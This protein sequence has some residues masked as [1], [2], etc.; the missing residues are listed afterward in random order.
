MA[1]SVA[2][3]AD[4]ESYRK[5]R[6]AMIQRGEDPGITNSALSHSSP[7]PNAMGSIPDAAAK[8]M[9][10]K[11]QARKDAVKKLF[12]MKTESLKGGE[13]QSAGAGTKVYDG[14]GKEGGEPIPGHTDPVSR[15]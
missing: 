8:S 11:H 5:R 2:S 14:T 12:G 9:N 4:L 3:T 1:N 13:I 10:A 6:E 7:K 15:D